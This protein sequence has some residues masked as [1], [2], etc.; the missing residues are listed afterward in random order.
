MR[1]RALALSAV[2]VLALTL[3]GCGP[4]EEEVKAEERANRQACVGAMDA[5]DTATNLIRSGASSHEHA[6]NVSDMNSAAAVS[7]GEG[8]SP[9]REAAGTYAD[10]VSAGADLSG[11][12]FLS[13]DVAMVKL[14]GACG[15]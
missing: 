6:S 14:K 5:Y 2:A 10:W 3:V 12:E 15:A 4:S 13:L 11:S 7:R 1:S 8:G 9:I